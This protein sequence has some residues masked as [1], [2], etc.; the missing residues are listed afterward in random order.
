MFI[1]TIST[2]NL[3]KQTVLEIKGQIGCKYNNSSDFNTPF[4]SIDRSSR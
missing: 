4:S 3:I 2:T 1:P